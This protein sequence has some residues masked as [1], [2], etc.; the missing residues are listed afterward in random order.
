MKYQSILA[1]TLIAIVATLSGC[2]SSNEIVKVSADTY[3]LSRTDRGGSMSDVASTKANM[4]RQADAFAMSQGKVVIP[5]G[6]KEEPMAVQGFT[7]IEY[8]F[9]IAEKNSA[10]ALAAV[11]AKHSTAGNTKLADSNVNVKMQDQKEHSQ[12]MYNELVK[13]DELRKRGILTDAEFDSEKK[14]VLN[15]N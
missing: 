9:Q 10:V 1:P 7:A 13:L 12:D 2:A 8:Q 14:K 3:K 15:R 5:I 4:E 6:I 11:E